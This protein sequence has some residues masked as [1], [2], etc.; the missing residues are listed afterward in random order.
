MWIYGGSYYGGTSTLQV[1]DP[2]TLASEMN[3]IVASLQYRVASLGF[4]YLGAEGI[5][6]NQ[7]LL[8]QRLAMKWIKENVARFGGNPQNITLFSGKRSS[9]LGAIHKRCQPIFRNLWPPSPPLSAQI[10]VEKT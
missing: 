7:G 1:Y 2:K 8:D 3:V 5:E 4:L 6:G 9:W 10:K